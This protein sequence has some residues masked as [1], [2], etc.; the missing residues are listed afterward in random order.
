MRNLNLLA[1]I[2]ADALII[3]SSCWSHPDSNLHVSRNGKWKL[4]R[5]TG[6]LWS[7]DCPNTMWVQDGIPT[8]L[9]N[10]LGKPGSY[11]SNLC[12]CVKTNPSI[13]ARVECPRLSFWRV[14]T[15]GRSTSW[16]KGETSTWYSLSSLKS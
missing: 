6:R 8:F 15:K 4:D 10:V 13:Q 12:N 1:W 5:N 2:R 3:L 14:R 11:T 9:W 7:L 16:A